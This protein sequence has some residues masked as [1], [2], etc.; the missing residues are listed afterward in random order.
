MVSAETKRYIYFVL[1]NCVSKAVPKKVVS[2]ASNKKK[3]NKTS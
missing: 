1:K 3:K 2:L